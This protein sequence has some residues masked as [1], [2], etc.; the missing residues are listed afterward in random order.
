MTRFL[1]LLSRHRAGGLS[2]SGRDWAI[3]FRLSRGTD[4]LYVERLQLRDGACAVHALRFGEED[5]FVRWCD[6]GR[7]QFQHPLVHSNLK[8]RGCALL[9]RAP[10]GNAPA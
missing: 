2:A 3:D 6:A 1:H 9:A 5:E 4:R 8:R 10:A 7:L